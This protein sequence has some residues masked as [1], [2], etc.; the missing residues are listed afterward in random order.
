MY[1]MRKVISLSVSGAFILFFLFGPGYFLIYSPSVNRQV[2][3]HNPEQWLTQKISTLTDIKPGNAPRVIWARESG[4]QT[5]TA[6]LY[7]HGFSASPQEVEPLITELS[8]ALKSNSYSPLMPGHGRIN[9]KMEKLSADQMFQEALEAYHVARRMGDK[10]VVIG[11]STGA[12]L[13]L[14]LASQ[15]LAIE[16]LILVSPNLGI[17]DPRGFLAAGPFGYWVLRMVLGEQYQW[18]PKFAGQENFW[19]TRY[20]VNGVRVMTDIVNESNQLELKKINIPTLT[21]WTARDTVVDIE[22]SLK[23]IKEMPS[24]QNR[25]VEV[26]SNDH[27]LAGDITSPETNSFVFEQV[28]EF[29]KG[30]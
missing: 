6:L 16:G 25:L 24:T 22:K 18:I 9:D 4:S 2:E 19:T 26:K 10:V 23:Q 13:A 3:I 28:A 14:W 30:L 17:R 21:L 1:V 27:V 5:S 12:A 29:I 11:T 20:D 7:L 15:N 8:S